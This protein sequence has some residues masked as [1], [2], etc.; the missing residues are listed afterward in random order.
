LS[1]HVA[2]VCHNVIIEEMNTVLYCMIVHYNRSTRTHRSSLFD[3][4]ATLIPA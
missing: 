2:V 1:V 4:S 3:A